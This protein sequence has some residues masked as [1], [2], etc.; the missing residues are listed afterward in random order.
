VKKKEQAAVFTPMTVKRRGLRAMRSAAQSHGLFSF[1]LATSIGLALSVKMP[2]PEENNLLQLILLQRPFLFYGIKWAYGTMLFTT[3]YIAASLLFSLAYIF[4]PREQ[5]QV[6]GGKLPPY[7]EIAFRDKLFLVLGEVH[8]PKRP[9]PVDHP[10]W[11]IIPERGL[12]TGLAVFGAIGSGKTT[13]AILPFAEQILGYR[14]A[15]PAKH[16]GGLILAGC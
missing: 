6:A 8:H 7:P 2:F 5:G 14:A 4:I 16:I 11:L 10:S 1:A 13:G 3:P 12:F 9:E 15:D